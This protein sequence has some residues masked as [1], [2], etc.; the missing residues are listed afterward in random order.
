MRGGSNVALYHRWK[1]NGSGF[2]EEIPNSIN[3]GR[4]LQIKRIIML[5]NNKDAPKRGD[6]NYDPD[7]NLYFAYKAIV[8]TFNDITKWD[9]LEQSGGET[10]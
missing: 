8:H 7:Y 9:D 6:T 1:N 10:T 3:I 5:C 2:D 4:W